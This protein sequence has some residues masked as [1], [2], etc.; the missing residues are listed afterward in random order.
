MIKKYLLLATLCLGNS[1]FGQKAIFRIPDTLQNKDY[2][3]LFERIEESENEHI[4]QSLYLKSFL[5]KAKSEKN[6]EEILNGYKNYVYHSA[7]NLKLVYA[8]SMIYIA[9]KSKNNALLGS[10]YLSKGIIYYAQKKH[11]QALDN[12]LIANNFI[13]KTVFFYFIYFS[14]ANNYLYL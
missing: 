14:R 11:N 2:D 9:K 7:E 4:K 13:S 1:I 8:D 6:S 3:Y 12:Y 10:A 5:F